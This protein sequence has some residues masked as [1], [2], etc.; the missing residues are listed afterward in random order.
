MEGWAAEYRYHLLFSQLLTDYDKGIP[1]EVTGDKRL[2]N[3]WP[4]EIKVQTKIR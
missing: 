4:M 3:Q 1:I 2:V